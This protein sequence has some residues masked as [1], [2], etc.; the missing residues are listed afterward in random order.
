M[1]IREPR[2]LLNKTLATETLNETL[3]Y[4]PTNGTYFSLYVSVLKGTSPVFSDITITIKKMVEGL[5]VDPTATNSKSFTAAQQTADEKSVI[6]STSLTP[7]GLCSE[8][9]IV[10]TSAGNLDDVTL[11]IIAMEV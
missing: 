3:R 4:S 5:A 10:V 7:S 2:K 11:R 8:Y 6:N 1:A 9:E